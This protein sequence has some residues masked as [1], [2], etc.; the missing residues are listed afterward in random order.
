MDD[1]NHGDNNVRTNYVEF[2]DNEDNTNNNM[3]IIIGIN[4]NF[5]FLNKYSI[6]S[7]IINNIP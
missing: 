7:K 3:T 5:L 6:R 1:N 2:S 4:H